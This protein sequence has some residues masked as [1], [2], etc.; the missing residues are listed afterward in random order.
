MARRNPRYGYRRIAIMS[1]LGFG[2]AWRLWNQ[3]DF[4]LAPQRLRPKRPPVTGPNRPCQA[5]HPRHVWTYEILFDRLADGTPFKV[6]SIL[7]E[8]TWECIAIL[9]ATSIRAD[10]VIALLRQRF[11]RRG[12]PEFLQSDN[13]SVHRRA[14]TSLA[15]SLSGR[16]DLYC[17]WPSLAGRVHRV[18]P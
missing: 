8:F 16:I 18:L 15:G 7:D 11:R 13:G 1:K 6:L 9:V 10:D 14:R 2:R 17:A 3:H 4:Q 5:D 12:A